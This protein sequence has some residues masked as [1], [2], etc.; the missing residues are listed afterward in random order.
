MFEIPLNGPLIRARLRAN[1]ALSS[2]ARRFAGIEQHQLV[3]CGFPRSGT[4]LLY[5]MLSSSLPGYRFEPFEQY[6]MYRIHRL[7]NYATKAPLDVFHVPWIDGLNINQKR[8]VVLVLLRDIRDVLTSRHPLLPD[9]YFIGHDHSWWPQGKGLRDWR[10]DAPGA[11]AIYE[12]IQ[13]IRGRPDTT[14][15]R[16]EDLVKDPD[17][18]QASIT[19]KYG[20]L[21]DSPFS[22]YHQR[23]EKHAY[24]YEGR[25]TPVDPELVKEGLKSSSDRV[26]RWRKRP[27]DVQRILDQF[28]ECDLLFAVLEDSGY[29]TSREWFER[30]R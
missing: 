11:L 22:E 23:P 29:E 15:I 26:A 18:V 19:A 27:A 10:F 21:F 14:L 16:Y 17:A 5:N 6:F 4:S 1:A 3:V 20:L 12:A 24:K 9:Q 13:S 8:L 28:S 7:G 25:Y 30:L 2:L